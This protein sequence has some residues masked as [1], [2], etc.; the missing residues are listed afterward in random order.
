MAVCMTEGGLYC[1]DKRPDAPI[2]FF[3]DR[4]IEDGIAARFTGCV[5]RG[6]MSRKEAR[7]VRKAAVANRLA[8]K[9]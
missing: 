2:R 7:L 9:V 6:R 8:G 5:R 3:S 1:P 4:T